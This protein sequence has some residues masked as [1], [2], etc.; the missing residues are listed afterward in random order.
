MSTLPHNLPDAAKP[1]TAAAVLRE[2][3]SGLEVDA[4]IRDFIATADDLR[5]SRPPSEE[6]AKMANQ[7]AAITRELFP[8]KLAI[9]T[10]VDPEIRDDV[11]LL[12]QIEASGSVEEILV[13]HDQWHR[14]VLP[15]APKWPG[16]LRLAIDAR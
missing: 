14:R 1:Q 9:E 16:L 15:L 12:F 3:A 5:A 10:G 6:L 11:C 8:G 4:A 7:V 13:R 2:T